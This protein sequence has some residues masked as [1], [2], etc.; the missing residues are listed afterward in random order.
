MG[1]QGAPEA[2]V[3]AHMQHLD[4]VLGI[5]AKINLSIAKSKYKFGYQE[6]KLLGYMCGR[7]GFRMDPAKTSRIKD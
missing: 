7:E 6:L 3:D 1:L 4:A 5:A 2:C